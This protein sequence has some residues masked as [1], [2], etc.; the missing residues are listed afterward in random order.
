MLVPDK[1][2]CAIFLEWEYCKLAFGSSLC[3]CFHIEGKKKVL[4][5]CSLW[6]CCAVVR[7][8]TVVLCICGLVP[9]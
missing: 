6:K 5:T 7:V 3:S 1:A 4:K 8:V 9:E 2:V